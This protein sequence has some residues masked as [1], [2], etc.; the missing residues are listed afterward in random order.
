[1]TQRH[2]HEACPREGGE[3]VSRALD[4]RFHGNDGV[5]LSAMLQAG[6]LAAGDGRHNPEGLRSCRDLL[7]QRGIG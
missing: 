6:A 1:M 2:T 7:G 4:S 3:W 5:N